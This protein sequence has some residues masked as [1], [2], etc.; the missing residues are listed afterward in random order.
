MQFADAD[1][2]MREHRPFVTKLY[3]NIAGQ[4]FQQ[5]YHF[6]FHHEMNNLADACVIN[7]RP[8]I[9]DG[10]RKPYVDIYLKIVAAQSLL[11]IEAVR[12]PDADVME[13]DGE[14]GA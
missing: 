9:A 14:H 11:G 1:L 13:G 5:W 2:D 3:E 4:H 12:S 10:G 7:Q 8:I 6:A